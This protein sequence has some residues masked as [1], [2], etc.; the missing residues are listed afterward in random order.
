MRDNKLIKIIIYFFAVF[1]SIFPA[2][3]IHSQPKDE[4]FQQFF[5]DKRTEMEKVSDNPELMRK[6]ILKQKNVNIRDKDGKTLLHYA[7][8]KGYLDVIK[9]LLEK[10]ADINAKDKDG[11]TPLH[12]AIIYSGKSYELITFLIEKGA[13]FNLKDKDGDIPIYLYAFKEANDDEFITKVFEFCVQKGWNIK[14]SV[15]A[16]F[17]NEFLGRRHKDVA[18]FL[19]KQ[20]IEFN[21]ISLRVSVREGY[22]DIFNLLIEKG[23]NPKQKDI[24]KSACDTDREN[25]TIIKTLLEKGNVPNEEDID[26]CMFKGHKE[27]S[28]LLSNFIKSTQGKEI[29]IKRRC[30]LKPVSGRCKGNFWGG[31]YDPFKK[32][33]QAFNYGGCNDVVPFDSVEACRNI[34]EEN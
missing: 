23:G 1:L 11:K 15:K 10:G 26:V 9:L 18:L 30:Y 3:I 25:L 32:V 29:D 8:Q 5:T 14:K 13:D 24:I 16:N 28:I 34:C 27:A 33:C 2:T 21:D 17:L 20:G 12:D 31:Y 19:L 7:A 6:Y 22:D 4:I